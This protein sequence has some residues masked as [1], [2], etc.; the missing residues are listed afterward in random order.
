MS[1]KKLVLE[2]IVAG[3]GTSTMT[4]D[5]VKQS[6]DASTVGSAM[7]AMID[8]GAFATQKGAAYTAIASAQYVETTETGLFDNTDDGTENDYPAA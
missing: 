5:D 7:Q 8:S 6:L 1:E 2:F 3:G 4:L